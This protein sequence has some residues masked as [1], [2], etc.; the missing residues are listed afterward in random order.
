MATRSG[1]A[2]HAR[3]RSVSVTISGSVA[4]IAL[5]TSFAFARS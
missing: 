2:H 1:C 4:G 5:K 3:G